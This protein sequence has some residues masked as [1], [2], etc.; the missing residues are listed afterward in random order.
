MKKLI[1]V[2][3]TLA[4]ILSLAAGVFAADATYYVAGT[5]N[6]WN[7]SGTQMELVDGVYSAT[8]ALEAGTHEFKI[9]QGDWNKENWGDNGQNYKFAVTSACNVTITFNATTKEIGVSGTGVGEAKMEI[10][11]VT[12]VGD[13]RNGFLNDAPW[14]PTYAS[15]KM[16]ENNGVYSITYTDVEAGTYEYKFAANGQWTDNWG[17]GG[18]T[19]SGVVC[20]AVYNSGTNAKVVVAENG[21][22]VTLTLDLSGMDSKGNGAKITATVSVPSEDEGG[23]TAGSVIAEG[24][25][26]YSE[27]SFCGELNYYTATE[28]GTVTVEISACDP[29]YCV[30]VFNITTEELVEEF[31][32]STPETVSFDV[33]AGNDYEIGVNVYTY[34]GPT[35]AFASAGTLTYK[36]TAGAAGESGGEEQPEIIET[37]APETL[38]VGSNDYVIGTDNTAAVVSNF[39]ATQAGTLTIT[40]TALSAHDGMAWN[41]ANPGMQFGMMYMLVINGET[42][43]SPSTTVEV[44]VGDVVSIGVMSAM[45]TASQITLDLTFDAVPDEGGDDV[46]GEEEDSNVVYGDGTISVSGAASTD[47]KPWTYIFETESAGILHIVIGECNPG[48]RYK[49]ITPDGIESL[50]KTKFNTGADKEFE[51]TQV[52]TYEIRIYAYS[53]AEAGNVDGTISADI[54]FTP[55][56]IEVEIP[57]EEYIVSGTDLAIGENDLTMEENAENTLFEFEPTEIGTYTF[58]A[59]EGVLIGDW[60]TTTY[61]FDVNGDSKTN[62]VVWECTAVGQSKLIGVVGSEDTVLTVTKTADREEQEQ[63]VYVDYE[64]VHIP[65]DDNLVDTTDV[66][67]NNID[68]TKP[69]TVVKDENGFYHLGSVEGPMIYVDLM[70]ESFDLTGAYYSDYGALVMRGE[71]DGTKYDFLGAMRDYASTVYMSAYDNGLYPLTDDL[72]AFLKGFGSYQ[73]WYMPNLSPFEN[74]DGTENADSAW[75]ASCV[76]LGEEIVDENPGEDDSGEETPGTGDYSVAGLVV[77]MMAATA[78]AIVISKKKEF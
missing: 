49:I 78:G 16:T 50:Y 29:G 9:T 42:V 1:S 13:G 56:D 57:K 55:D 34:Y 40:A 71:Y 18:E 21:S 30:S 60:N 26:N 45:G 27:T 39:T 28:D 19:A 52:G 72:V 73:G 8:F 10:N 69:Q 48:W 25:L 5:M 70:S 32:N 77:A 36:I 68:I 14:D 11:Y 46:G 76:Y 35:L 62:V 17:Y 66:Q 58:T 61:P 75:L 2:V 47:K 33:V 4:M 51:M 24:S 54:T 41:E 3:L 22:T 23:E 43:Y 37:I 67:V 44:A 15:N 20:D 38:V 65:S 31:K 63:I 64:N 6:G 53:S 7:V 74:I 59:P 12:A